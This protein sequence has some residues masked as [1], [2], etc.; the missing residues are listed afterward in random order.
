MRSMLQR[1]RIAIV[2]LVSVGS[3]VCSGC[4]RPCDP[5]HYVMFVLHDL[6]LEALYAAC[7]MLEALYAAALYAA[8]TA[9]SLSFSLL[10][11][12]LCLSAP[13]AAL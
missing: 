4:G 7:S 8:W 1:I 12:P 13:S 9:L 6:M 10:H 2:Y 5:G 11:Q 3:C